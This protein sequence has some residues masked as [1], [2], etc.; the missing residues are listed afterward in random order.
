MGVNTGNEGHFEL[1]YNMFLNENVAI[2][3]D[4][5]LI[6]NVGGDKDFNTVTVGA[7]RGQITF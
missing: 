2:T 7:V 4:I 3:P 1:Y 6:T 5:Q